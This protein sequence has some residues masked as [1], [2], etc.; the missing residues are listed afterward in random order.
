MMTEVWSGDHRAKS[1]YSYFASG[2]Y[3]VILLVEKT[4]LNW[5]NWIL[6]GSFME[7]GGQQ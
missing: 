1:S 2:I 7:I 5:S 3:L 4:F 6:L